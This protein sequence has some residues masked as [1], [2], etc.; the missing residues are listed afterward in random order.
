MAVDELFGDAV[1]H[2]VHGEA[3]PFR[4][5]L[6]VERRLHQNIPQFLAHGLGV[7]PVQSVQGLVCLLQKIPA[8]GIVGLLG[9]PGAASRCTQQCHD[10]KKIRP[11]IAGLTL[12]IYHTLSAF[13]RKFIGE[14]LE[15]Q[16]FF[17]F[18]CRSLIR[19]APRGTD[20]RSSARRIRSATTKMPYTTTPAPMP[21][22][23]ARALAP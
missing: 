12:K 8:D 18:K 4:L 20:C 19:A 15:N 14:F 7:I 21:T 1:H 5:D 22:A 6:G 23:V 17:H 13:A 9:V 16:D 2:V 3:A 11:V 10:V